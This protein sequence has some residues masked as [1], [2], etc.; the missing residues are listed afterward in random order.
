MSKQHVK[1]QGVPESLSL[2]LSTKPPA[3]AQITLGSVNCML[4]TFIYSALVN[5]NIR[6]DATS[7]PWSPLSFEMPNSIITSMQPHA[8][9]TFFPLASGSQLSKAIATEN[10]NLEENWQELHEEA[11]SAPQVPRT[12]GRKPLDTH[13]R[14]KL[15]PKAHLHLVVPRCSKMS[16]T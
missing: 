11:S 8:A 1:T 5:I 3:L 4:Y 6:D 16:V 13:K 15:V 12:A 9:W 7:K 2:S 10:S 14:S